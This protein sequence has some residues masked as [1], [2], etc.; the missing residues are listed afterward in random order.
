MFIHVSY[1]RQTRSDSAVRLN[2]KEWLAEVIL[3][4]AR[5]NTCWCRFQQKAVTL[6]RAVHGDCFYENIGKRLFS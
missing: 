2:F 6:K 4:I 3:E 5:K 1:A